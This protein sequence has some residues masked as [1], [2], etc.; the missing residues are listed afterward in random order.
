MPLSPF[1]LSAHKLPLFG[2]SL[3]A[4]LTTL[5]A[6]QP[7]LYEHARQHVENINPD[8]FNERSGERMRKSKARSR[9]RANR[10]VG[11]DKRKRVIR[12]RKDGNIKNRSPKVDRLRIVGVGKK[13]N[14]RK[15]ANSGCKENEDVGKEKER[16]GEK[17]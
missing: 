3:S 1:A 15:R 13:E 14:G 12:C 4:W 16:D 6:T 9:V 10:N 5:R 17:K 7:S 11:M 8:W 2:S